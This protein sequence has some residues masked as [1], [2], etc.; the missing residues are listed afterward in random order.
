MS[1]SASR[2]SAR[3]AN[4]QD[5]SSPNS[6]DNGSQVSLPPGTSS[7]VPSGSHGQALD[8]RFLRGLP[9]N[10]KKGVR[11]CRNCGAEFEQ[12][13]RRPK[14]YCSTKCRDEYGNTMKLRGSELYATAMRWRTLRGQKSDDPTTD[15]GALLG[16]MTKLLDRWIAEDAKEG[17]GLPPLE[18]IGP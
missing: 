5:R 4:S 16:R 11:T 17:R 6:T 2:A 15:A 1:T 9:E 18:D 3:K 10:P 7:S 8:D 13:G 14:R 12:K